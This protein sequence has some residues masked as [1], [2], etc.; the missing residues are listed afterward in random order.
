MQQR[1]DLRGLLCQAYLTF[2][3][4]AM[5]EENYITWLLYTVN[6]VCLTLHPEDFYLLFL[7]DIL[8][9]ARKTLSV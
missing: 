8:N 3:E 9:D 4:W 7:T 2:L 6:C 5:Y 1:S